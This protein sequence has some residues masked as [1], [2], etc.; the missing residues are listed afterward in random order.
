MS[1]YSPIN[2]IIQSKYESP[3]HKINRHVNT[4]IQLLDEQ[5]ILNERITYLEKENEQLKLKIPHFSS[6]GKR[7]HAHL[8]FTQSPKKLK[9]N[10]LPTD[11]DMGILKENDM[12]EIN[13]DS[14]SDD[15]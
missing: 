10:H 8:I 9:F 12:D 1:T 5:R 2:Q 13:N 6:L 7:K 15:D 4:I 3:E 14:F 11:L